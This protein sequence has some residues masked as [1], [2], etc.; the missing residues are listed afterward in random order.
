M[1]KKEN[2]PMIKK[3]V[4]GTIHTQGINLAIYMNNFQE[5]FISLTDIDRYK[6]EKPFSVIATGFEERIPF[7]F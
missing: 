4:K 5:E 2:Q 6:S 7:S 3:T 1:K